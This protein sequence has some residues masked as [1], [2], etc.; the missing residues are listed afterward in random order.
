MTIPSPPKNQ[1]Q[2]KKGKKKKK[3][4]KKNQHAPFGQLDLIKKNWE[5]M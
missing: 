5:I 1:K 2:T 3:P 4:K